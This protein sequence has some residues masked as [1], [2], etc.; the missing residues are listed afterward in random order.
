MAVDGD[1]TT[2]APQHWSR[3]LSAIVALMLMPATLLGATAAYD[4]GNAAP[5]L[6]P[7]GGGAAT[8]SKAQ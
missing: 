1:A 8:G 7:L 6:V 4:T 2:A 3:E 5:P